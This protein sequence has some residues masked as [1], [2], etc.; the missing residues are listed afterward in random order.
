MPKSRT[1]YWGPKILENRVR[2]ARK[3]RLL[4]RL[5]WRSLVVWECETRNAGKLQRKL[6]AFL[7]S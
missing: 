1:D 4:T 5:G 7:K 2:D 6:A 3:R